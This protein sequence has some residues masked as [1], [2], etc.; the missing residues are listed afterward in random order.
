MAV[1]VTHSSQKCTA[2]TKKIVN[3]P[4]CQFMQVVSW[5]NVET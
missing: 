3:E 2:T 4:N 5:Q 1:R